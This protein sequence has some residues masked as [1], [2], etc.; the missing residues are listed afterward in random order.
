MHISIKAEALFH[1]LGFPVTNSLIVI[2]AVMVLLV[3]FS[4]LMTRRLSTIPGKG[5]NAIEMMFEFLLGVFDG[6]T[7]DRA[8]TKKIFPLV[9]TIFI[10]ILAVN[11]SGL[12]PGV[13]TI[14]IQ[15]V[16]HEGTRLIPF[17][18]AT[19]ADL[20]FTLALSLISVIMV[21]IW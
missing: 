10:A 14:G 1:I 5:Q 11:W 4:W 7:G 8:L 16:G 3:V 19:S 6:V 13:G 20:N 12:L 9:A 15:E 2:W 17:F 21:Q 18:R